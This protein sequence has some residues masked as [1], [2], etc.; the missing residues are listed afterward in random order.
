MAQYSVIPRGREVMRGGVGGKRTF[1]KVCSTTGDAIRPR[2]F[3]IR[4]NLPAIRI[5]ATNISGNFLPCG[6]Q[7]HQSSGSVPFGRRPAEGA[8]AIE[9]EGF[10]PSQKEVVPM[11]RWKRFC[12][13]LTAALALLFAMGI[14]IW[15]GGVAL[16]MPV[17]GIGGFIVEADEI[18]I[19]N[20]K[21]LPKIG[22]T[23]EKSVY[24]QA[25]SSLDGVIKGMKLYKDFEL[26][27]F[28]ARVLIKASKDVKALGLVLDMTRMT[29]DS[30]FS[31]LKVEENTTNSLEK[32]S[33]SATSLNLKN[34][35]IRG[36]YLFANSISIPGMSLD[37]SL[38]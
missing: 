25:S 13:S 33:L 21:L 16:A 10:Q 23:S 2:A 12:V 30:S 20:F 35:K 32:L 34:V 9:A 3:S 38:K 14:G 18:Q 11:Y 29:A 17:A 36:H 31:K 8:G 24:P 22:Q 19:T 5:V 15:T 28:K 1:P 26:G 37:V 4:Q 6:S 7:S 27:S